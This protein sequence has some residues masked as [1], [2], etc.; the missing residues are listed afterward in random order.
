MPVL[1]CLNQITARK[2]LLTH[3]AQ[4]SSSL[5]LALSCSLPLSLS[6]LVSEVVWPKAD[7]F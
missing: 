2:V 1:C 6:F 5:S 3:T 7:S 4:L